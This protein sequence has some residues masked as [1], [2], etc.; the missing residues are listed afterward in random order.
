VILY[1]S[2]DETATASG[3]AEACHEK[4][5]NTT[6]TCDELAARGLIERRPKQGRTV[7][8]QAMPEVSGLFP[9]AF[10][11]LAPAELQQMADLYARVLDKLDRHAR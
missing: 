9:E 3:L 5:A 6:R 2:V 4:P 7:I 10:G 1:G 8:P 11:S